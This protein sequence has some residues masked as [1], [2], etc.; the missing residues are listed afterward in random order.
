MRYHVHPKVQA[1]FPDG[2]GIFKDD[3]ALIH[4]A[5]V[6]KNYHK[7]HESELEYMEWPL[8]SPDLIIIEHL[9][10]VLERQV[11]NRHLPLSCLKVLDQILMEEWLKIPLD[12]N[13]KPDNSI[14]RQIE[15]AQKSGR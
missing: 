1:L 12:K 6:V 3:N 10:C 13:R 11:R 9:W 8:Q 5:H 15:S 14:S 7:E 2:D 4:T